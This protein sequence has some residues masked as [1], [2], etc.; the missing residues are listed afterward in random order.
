MQRTSFLANEEPLDALCHHFSLAKALFPSNTPL[1]PTFDMQIIAPASRMPTHVLAILPPEDN[2][3]PRVPTLMVPVDAHMYHQCFGGADLLP[4]LAPGAPASVPHF[5]PGAQ[6]PSVTLPVVPVNAPHGVSIPLL[7]LFGLG[8][9]TDL[10]LLATRL[11]P[12]NAIGEFPNAAE[13]SR[14]MSRMSDAE[15]Q[16]YLQYNLGIWKNILVLAPRNVELVGLVQT[17]YKVVADARRMRGR[18]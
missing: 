11:L 16:W 13:C 12:A 2:P 7:L 10:N 9:E 14:V 1:Q 17:A 4:Q 15:F 3:R 8:L 5:D 6:I 18:G